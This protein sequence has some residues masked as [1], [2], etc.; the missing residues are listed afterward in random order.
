MQHP[1]AAV[2]KFCELRDSG[3]A[4]FVYCKTG[5]GSPALKHGVGTPLNVIGGATSARTSHHGGFNRE[6]SSSPSTASS[7]NTD[8]IDGLRQLKDVRVDHSNVDE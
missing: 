2:W 1:L 4:E 5:S 6:E 3:Y 7:V 8:F